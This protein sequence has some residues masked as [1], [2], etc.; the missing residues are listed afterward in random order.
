MNGSSE[1]FVLPP[2]LTATWDRA[3]ARE[4]RMIVTGAIVVVGVLLWAFVWRP[5][6]ADIGPARDALAQE[7]ARLAMARREVNDMASLGKEAPAPVL[8]ELRAPVERV[9][10]ARG[11][12]GAVTALDVTPDSAHVVLGS[13]S[14]PALIS[15]I[16]ALAKDEHLRVVEATLTARVEPG[17][18][19]ADLTLAR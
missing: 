16:D 1:R 14:F 5:I 8:A 13:V 15:L 11:L 6:V 17:T 12:R 19:R 3:S 10:G 2:A 9:L 4:R 7:Q 18:L